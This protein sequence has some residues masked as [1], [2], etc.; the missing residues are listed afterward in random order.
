MLVNGLTKSRFI[1]RVG[2]GGGGGGKTISR[3]PSKNRLFFSVQIETRRVNFVRNVCFYWMTATVMS[4][5][6]M[7]NV[8]LNETDADVNQKCTVAGR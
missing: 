3:L 6:T 7:V 8:E 1:L 5:M 2:T 4:R